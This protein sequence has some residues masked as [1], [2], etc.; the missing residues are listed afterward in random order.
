[1]KNYEYVLDP[2]TPFIKK[3]YGEEDDYKAEVLTPYGILGELKKLQKENADLETKL[4]E[5]EKEIEGYKNSKVFILSARQNG[6]LNLTIRQFNEWQNRVAIEQLEKVSQDF[7]M[8]VGITDSNMD[9]LN[10]II[11]NQITQLKEGK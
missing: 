6:K 10:E 4:A 2:R 8:R 5:K 11:D 9:L 7:S 3:L 1:M